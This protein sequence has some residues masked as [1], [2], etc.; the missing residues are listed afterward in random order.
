MLLHESS[1][2]ELQYA[3]RFNVESV[4]FMGG[5]GASLHREDFLG[6]NEM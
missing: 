6:T 1:A 3:R 2:N 4:S 5:R